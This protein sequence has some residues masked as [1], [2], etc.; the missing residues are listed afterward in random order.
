MKRGDLVIP[1]Y[2]HKGCM[3]Y[4]IVISRSHQHFY[5]N[6]KVAIVFA[7]NARDVEM[8]KAKWYHC[9]HWVKLSSQKEE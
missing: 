1:T 9:T 4:G 6:V 7:S 5:G 3:V 8:Y 2:N